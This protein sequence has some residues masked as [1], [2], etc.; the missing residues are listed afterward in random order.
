MNLN[1]EKALAYIDLGSYNK[2]VDSLEAAIKEEEA[3]GNN[4]TAIE[5]KCVL[6]ELYAQLDMPLQAQ[7]V[8]G[9]VVMFCD[10]NC[11]LAEQ[12]SIAV[13]YLIAYETN[14]ID[15]VLNEQA[16]RE[17]KMAAAKAAAR[18]GYLPLVPKP[19]QDK[20]FISRQMGKKRR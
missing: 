20:G 6:G 8:L 9:E 13:K 1:L 18:P 15:A 17:G 4:Q 12:R 2:A 19:M 11:C 7:R 10:E 16:V 14:T 3:A 5:Y